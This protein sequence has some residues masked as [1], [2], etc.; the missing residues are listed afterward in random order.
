MDALEAD[1]LQ[2]QLRHGGHPVLA[3]QAGNVAIQQD[4]N[5]NI[6]PSKAKSNERIDGIVALVMALG[7]HASQEVKGPAMEPSILIL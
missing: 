4:H 7:V 3:W 6:K 5:G 2:E 1:L